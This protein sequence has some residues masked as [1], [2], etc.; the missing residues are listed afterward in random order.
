MNAFNIVGKLTFTEC[1]DIIIKK[2]YLTFIRIHRI[3]VVHC[4]IFDVAMDDPL[5]VESCVNDVYNSCLCN[6]A[7]IICI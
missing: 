1:N 4:Y 3:P 2:Y 7:F 5:S 6:E